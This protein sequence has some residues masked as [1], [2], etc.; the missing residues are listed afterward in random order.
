MEEVAHTIAYD[1]AIMGD[2]I[3]GNPSTLKKW[4][5]VSTSTLVMNGETSHPHLQN[6]ARELANLL[7]NARYRALAGQGHGPANEVLTPAL[8]EFFIS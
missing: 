5:S 6:A 1:G 2:T 8:Q 4:A 3:S 7:P